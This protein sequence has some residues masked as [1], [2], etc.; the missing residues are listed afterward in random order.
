M[1]SSV[2]I[3]CLLC[4]ALP[5]TNQ[6]PTDSSFFNKFWENLPDSKKTN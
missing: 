1:V 4:L 2:G 5:R 6:I 3:I